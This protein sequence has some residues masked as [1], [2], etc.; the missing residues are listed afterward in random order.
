M[1]NQYKIVKTL[2]KG[3]YATVKLV[4]D[5]NMELYAMKQMNKKELKSKIIA[6]GK[7]AYMSVLEELKVL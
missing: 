5:P 3:A 4:Q 6:K 7:N 1:I 2:G